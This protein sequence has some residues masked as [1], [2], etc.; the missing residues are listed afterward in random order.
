MLTQNKS[1][2]VFVTKL[3][4]GKLKKIMLELSKRESGMVRL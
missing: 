4:I 2:I 1:G 3:V